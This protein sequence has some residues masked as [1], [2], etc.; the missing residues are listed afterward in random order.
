MRF[1]V[2][3]VFLASLLVGA[4]DKLVVRP[5]MLMETIHKEVAFEPDWY[6]TG[7]LKYK[8]VLP[9]AGE[10][11]IRIPE[12]STQLTVKVEECEAPVEVILANVPQRSKV[13]VSDGK[14]THL[15][16]IPKD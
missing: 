5:A 6:G 7:E 12:I 14:T 15:W 13:F 8:V 9:L 2:P 11:L 1:F 10:Y 16:I 4:D 3:L